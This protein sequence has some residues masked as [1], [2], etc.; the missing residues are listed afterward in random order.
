MKRDQK[1][2]DISN[3]SV[4]RGHET[5]D[6]DAKSV[7]ISG[8]LLSFG[9]MAAGIL[10]SWGMY[11]F[12][13]SYTPTPGRPTETLVVPDSGKLPALPRLQADPHVAI[14]PLIQR[15]DSILASYG[16]VKKDSGL[17]RIPIERAMELIVK[18]G[19]P[20]QGQ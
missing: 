5:S 16:W 8:V 7:G 13:Q 9:L 19:L 12:F 17:A 11:A 20:V 1:H 10:F 14:V 2:T 6:A 3:D 18:N 4:G 15:Q